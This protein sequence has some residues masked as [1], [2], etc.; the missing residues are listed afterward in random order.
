MFWKKKNQKM[1]SDEFEELNKKLVSCVGNIDILGHSVEI[2]RGDIRKLRIELRQKLKD[3]EDI[4]NEND[5]KE[6]KLYL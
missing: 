3:L 5:K 2:F 4:E 6:D 1:R